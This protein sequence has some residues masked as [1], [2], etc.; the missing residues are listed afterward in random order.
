M[1]Y[2]AA[3]IFLFFISL[4]YRADANNVVYVVPQPVQ[5]VPVL[6]VM[7]YQ[8]PTLTVMVPVVV[9]PET[10][11]QQTVVWGYPYQVT[12]AP[13]NQYHHWGYDKRCRLINKY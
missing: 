9:Y 3:S 10:V 12:T 13:V 7:I 2:L 8:A 4:C 1:K 6:Q 5:Q 11:V